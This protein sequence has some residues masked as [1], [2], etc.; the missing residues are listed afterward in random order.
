MLNILFQDEHLVAI[1]KPPGLMVHRSA[2]AG[3]AERYALQMLRDQIHQ[4]V[5]PCHRLDRKTSGVL[6]FAKDGE[7]SK[8]MQSLFARNQVQ[9]NYLAIVRGFTES[10]GQIKHPLVADNGRQQEAITNYTTLAQT[11]ISVPSG[12]HNTSRY[13]LVLV[14]PE[15]GRTHQIRRHFAH[16][17]H[18]II[19][20]RPHGCNKQNRLFKEKWNMTTMM[21]H[22]LTLSFNHPRSNVPI[23]INAP[24]QTEFTRMMQELKLTN[25]E[26]AYLI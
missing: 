1:N 16:I 24:L 23:R 6:L 18:P 25:P 17:C 5:H 2:I 19:G 13:S 9:K 10:H 21:L 12:K 11:E 7:A 8:L 15:T 26:T 4:R 20:D 22:A 14:K 3:G